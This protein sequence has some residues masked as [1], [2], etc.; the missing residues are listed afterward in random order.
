MDW[1]WK[2]P[3]EP[4]TQPA[5]PVTRPEF[6]NLVRRVETLE[7]T[8]NSP[9]MVD[10]ARWYYRDELGDGGPIS[11]AWLPWVSKATRFTERLTSTEFVWATLGEAGIAGLSCT[12]LGA[13]AAWLFHL[14]WYASP[15]I[16]V[17][18]LALAGGVLLIHNR[19]MLHRLVT[20]QAKKGKQ[21]SELRV[22]VDN[23][24][25]G[26]ISPHA[27]FMYLR[28]DIK[29]EQLAEFA[30]ATLNGSGLAVHMWT[31]AGGVFTR[32]Q[33]D[34]LMSE[35]VKMEYIRPSAGNLARSLNQKGLALMKAL[36]ESG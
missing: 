35:L 5:Q 16:G 24:V 15:V 31:G 4:G 25:K 11:T 14:P 18:G 6:A 34:S 1:E 32:A 7:R 29:P 17:G 21:R 13:G 3:F 33:Y 26:R 12:I 20:E 36:A 10:Q 22:Q 19:E 30:R 8:V 28:C 27:E 23:P 9:V 2:N